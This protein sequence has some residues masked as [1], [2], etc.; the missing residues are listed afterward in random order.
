MNIHN[1]LLAEN[2]D[3]VI[4]NDYYDELI[5]VRIETSNING[6]VFMCNECEKC[7]GTYLPDIEYCSFCRRSICQEMGKYIPMFYGSA[8]GDCELDSEIADCLYNIENQICYYEFCCIDC[9]NENYEY[10]EC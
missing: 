1:R 8:V 3:E 2:N 9:I 5:D 7:S 10:E 6:E 4:D